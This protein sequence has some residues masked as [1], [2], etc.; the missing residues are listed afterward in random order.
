MVGTRSAQECQDK[1][2]RQFVLDDDEIDAPVKTNKRLVNMHAQLQ[3]SLGV[4]DDL[5]AVTTSAPPNPQESAEWDHLLLGGFHRSSIAF[6]R[7][8]ENHAVTLTVAP[9]QTKSCPS[10]VTSPSVLHH[11]V[12]EDGLVAKILRK[13]AGIDARGLRANPMVLGGGSRSRA[14]AVKGRHGAK[15]RES[16]ATHALRTALH[17]LTLKTDHHHHATLDEADDAVEQAADRRLVE[18]PASLLEY[19]VAFEDAGLTDDDESW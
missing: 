7:G 12:G 16:R 19:G 15:G 5:F 10:S 4:G 8:K 1:Y 18:Q 11:I 13:P 2:E 6:K 3:S 9:H 17:R 14:G